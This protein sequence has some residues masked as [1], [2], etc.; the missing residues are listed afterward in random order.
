M[1]GFLPV[2]CLLL[3]VVVDSFYFYVTPKSKKRCFLEEI[4]DDTP[5]QIAYTAPDTTPTAVRSY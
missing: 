3:A 5:V 4:P 1:R 2:L